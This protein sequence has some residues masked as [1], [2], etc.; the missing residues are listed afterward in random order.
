MSSA[1]TDFVCLPEV[2][3]LLLIIHSSIFSSLANL[4]E[5]MN[6][7]AEIV[8]DSLVED[9]VHFLDAIDSRHESIRDVFHH[10]L[11]S[12]GERILQGFNKLLHV[13]RVVAEVPKDNDEWNLPY[14]RGD[15]AVTD[16][17]SSI[18]SIT[19]VFSSSQ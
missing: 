6:A 2:K 1:Y 13:V 12:I 7:C 17:S 15:R 3:H 8:F 5:L 9:A 19:S 4:V 16:V 11:R 18:R 10:V 14:M